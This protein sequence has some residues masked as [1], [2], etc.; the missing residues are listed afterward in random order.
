MDIA[1]QL[2]EQL[3]PQVKSLRMAAGMSQMQLAQMLGISR[4][5]LAVIERDPLSVTVRQF[6]EIL[7]LLDAQL[8][9]RVSDVPGTRRQTH[10]LPI[11]WQQRRPQGR[12]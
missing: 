1:L 10:E 3:F 11:G 6:M 4:E 12:W 8:M 9:L 2:P 5:R 7:C